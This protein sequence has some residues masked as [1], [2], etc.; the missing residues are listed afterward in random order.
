MW[1]RG[2]TLC[3]GLA[4]LAGAAECVP[5]ESENAHVRNPSREV[6]PVNPWPGRT[7]KVSGPGRGDGVR[8]KGR[9]KP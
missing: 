7:R 9:T 4:A 3:L 1:L 6:M 5:Q 2:D 8:V